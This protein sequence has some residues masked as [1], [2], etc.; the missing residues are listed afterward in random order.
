MYKS[1]LGVAFHNFVSVPCTKMVGWYKVDRRY[2][3]Y[4]HQKQIV[5]SSFD[6]VAGSG[7]AKPYTA[8]AIKTISRHFSFLHDAINGKI[9]VARKS[10]R[11]EDCLANAEGVGISRLR[12][13]D[14]Q[15]RQ[16]EPFS[17]SERCNHMLG[18][19]RGDSQKLCFNF[20]R[21]AFRA[22]CSSVRSA[23]LYFVF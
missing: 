16:Q 11:E 13:V 3:Q 14:Q 17:N 19:H 22:L 15:L 6:V 2:R 10:L 1:V 23:K 4:Y 20:A 9:C 21:L 12:Y 5:V 7:S 18:G 8:I